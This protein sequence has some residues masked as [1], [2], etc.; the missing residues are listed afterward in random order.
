MNKRLINIF[1]LCIFALPAYAQRVNLIDLT[2]I[3]PASVTNKVD[4][5]IRMGITNHE[6]E[7]REIALSLYLNHEENDALLYDEVVTLQPHAAQTIKY[8]MP[9]AGKAGNYQIILVAKEGEKLYRK[10]KNIEI[11]D[12]PIR[13]SQL[14][15]GAW[16]GIYHWSETEGKHWNKDLKQATGEQ[17]KA[18]VQ[19]M[20]KAG[21]DIVVI[22]E[23]FR[24]EAYVGK[25]AIT[26]DNYPGKAFYPSSLYPE[27]MPIAAE[28]PV[29]A[30]LSEADK[31]DMNVFMGVGMFAW[32]DFTQESLTWHKR[33]AEE[34]WNKYGHHASFY[35]FYVS[36]ESGG[37]LDNWEW[38]EDKRVQRK[39][40]IIRFFKEFKSFCQRLAPAKPI[41]LATNSMDVPAGKDAYPALLENL[42]ILCPFG[43]ARM[44]EHDLT[45][46]QAAT[47]LQELCDEAGAHLWFDLEAFLFHEDGSLYPKPAE[48]II[49]DL[50]LFN[51]FEKILC[52][53]FP[54]VFN[55]PEMAIRIGEKSTVDLFNAYQAY[56]SSVLRDG[57]H[58]EPGHMLVKPVKGTWL[59]LPYQDVRNKYMNP[60]HIDANNPDFWEQKIKE[61]AEIGLSY[62]IIMSIANEQKAY[63]PSEFMEPIYPSGCKSPVAAIM[64]AADKYNMNVF[65]SC[66]WAIN[67][68]DDLRKPEIRAIQQRIMTEAASLFGQHKSFYGWYL[69]VEDSFEPYLSEH[70]V[71][72]VNTLAGKA[73]QLTPKA[74]IMISPYGICH[75][76][77]DNEKFGEQIKKLKVDIIAYQDEVG[78]VRE[79]MP[80]KRMKA[81]F[82]QLNDIHRETNIRFWANVE[83]FTWEKA[84]NSRESALIPAAFPRYLS[85]IVGV[86]QAGVEEIVSFSIYGIYDNPNSP[87]FIGQPIES[88]IAYRN[89]SDWR[90]GKGRWALL[91]ATFKGD[92]NHAA[93]NKPVIFIS[94]ADEKYNKGNLTDKHMGVE[95]YE[96]SNWIGFDRKNMEV[97]IDLGA[98]TT[99]T[100]IAA[101]FLQY[102]VASIALPAMVDFYLSDDGENFEKAHTV[103]METTPNNLH[104][105]WIDIALADKINKG[106]RYVK[107]VAENEANM[108]LFCD[109]ILVNPK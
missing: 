82:K 53:Q 12:S 65:M 74:K 69:P 85:Q 76:D 79:P 6:N 94:Q 32:F 8:R 83:S 99:I 95:S 33:V 71:D 49:H 86:S 48:D 78:C 58:P 55:D 31:L 37:S 23:V 28:D 70:A 59:N 1:L 51:N 20:H 45:G 18:L 9:T 68:D 26:V 61:Y 11:I 30:I 62:L 19:S 89:Y 17:W 29:E 96:D 13:S 7:R 46:V 66:G 47:L 77:F 42:D 14:I 102:R 27:R 22:Q 64:D 67:Q 88:A 16:A 54:G 87:M 105:C 90:A 21:M 108:W 2:L 72:A 57:V 25:H 104:D 101:R 35:G 50:K 103:V 34:L 97:I 98:A 24:N 81:H 52:Y 10:I 38:S 60:P 91:E 5:D 40:E 84:T 93:A 4:L 73:R 106:A 75:A 36:E 15:G 56:R 39:N 109:E 44:P 107:V 3:P 43:F 41:M 92:I 63:Y 80:M 100:S